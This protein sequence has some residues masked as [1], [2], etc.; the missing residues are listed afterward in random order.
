MDYSDLPVKM[1]FTKLEFN[2]RKITDILIGMLMIAV[3]CGAGMSLTSPKAV[4]SEA[5]AEAGA[6]G[7]VTTETFHDAT[8]QVNL[9]VDGVTRRRFLSFTNREGGSP[10]VIEVTR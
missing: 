2:M 8:L 5:P 9:T 1:R 4:A 7:V 3:I 6:R 10:I